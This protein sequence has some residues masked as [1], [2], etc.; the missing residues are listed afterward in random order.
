MRLPAIS[1]AGLLDDRRL[2]L[3]GLLLLTLFRLGIAWLTPLTEDEAYYRLWALRPQ[4]GY[5]D[6]PPMIAWW[7][8]FGR[9]ISGD[10]PL[11]VRLLPVFGSAL[12]S[13]IL[14]DAARL[15]GASERLAARAAL[16][17]NATLLVGFGA[18][19]AVPDAPSTL[20]WTAALWALLKAR[21]TGKP[22]WWLMA[23]VAAG[24][25][26]LSKYSA[27][28]LAPG[29]F[30]WLVFSSEGRAELRKPWPWL[31]CITAALLFGVNAWWNAGH[32][33]QSFTKQFGRVSP[34]P[35][36]PQYLFE[37]LLLQPL[38]LNPLIAAFAWKPF[39]LRRLKTWGVDLSL[40]VLTV[41]PFLAYLMIHSL[42]ARVQEHWPAPLYP[43]LALMAAAAADGVE[44]GSIWGRLRAL[45][46]PF[47]IGVSAL[48]LIY[49]ASGLSW[50]G[51]SDPSIPLKSWPEFARQLESERRLTGAA[52]IGTLSYGVNGELS[53]QRAIKAPVLQ[54]MERDRYSFLP[55]SSADMGKPGLV[56][57]LA[58]REG[59]AA[60]QACF[61]EVRP[62]PEVVRGPLQ[63]KNTTYSTWLVSHP[64]KVVE[65]GCE[66]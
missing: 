4:L 38:L 41:L 53:A 46:A 39:D 32:H 12:T 50:L 17:F 28:F 66:R 19:L 15:A 52:W 54:L 34:G 24:L 6:H 58:R 9:T 51:K 20:F 3:R 29:V 30:L 55:P 48:L 8:A 63:V 44:P 11:G 60:L 62:L 1:F 59:L 45:A 57:D 43:A 18:M 49:A 64:R 14:W 22:L 65:G 21:A 7:I 13:V 40:F 25:A 61:A 47:G 5:Y 23:G 37:L 56:V 16:W 35:L 33:W 10:N 26:T 31:T 42:H 36:T 2:L 27:L